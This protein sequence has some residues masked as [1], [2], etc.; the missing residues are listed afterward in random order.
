[1]A[2]GH[3][4]FGNFYAAGVLVHRGLGSE[5][6]DPAAQ[7]RV[8]QD[9]SPEVKERGGP[10]RYLRPPFEALLFSVFTIWP[11]PRALLIW[12]C[13]KLAMLAAIPFV[14]VRDRPWR[15]AFPLWATG[16]LALG[17]FP[18]S[19][20]LYLGQDAVLVALLYAI[21]FWQLDTGRDVAAGV[22][23]GLALV[24]F[25]FAIPFMVMLWI[26]G[27]KRVL[28]G[29]AAS[30][31]VLLV[32]SAAVVGWRELLLHYPIYLLTLNQ[33]TGVGIQ[34][35][36]QVTFRGLLTILVG[37][38]TYPGRIHFVLLPIAIGA[39]IY[40]GWL[41]RKA[42]SGF[43]AEG[44]GLAAIVAIVSSYY[45]YCY[46]MILLMVPMLAMLTRPANA[47]TADKVTGY[48]ETSGV[49]L[50]L[51]APVY[52]F[53]KSTLHHEGLMAIPL[54]AVGIALARR[55]RHA[56]A[57]TGVRAPMAEVAG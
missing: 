51:L 6:Y 21:V 22:T 52:W 45:A 56:G 31:S 43:L 10:I 27:R 41:W 3:F 34:P 15:E 14:V 36:L 33:R 26:A 39:V 46:D 47:P 55:L 2:K 53:A 49:L 28:P 24:K 44:F 38:A 32:I 50:L 8:Q 29:F 25:H 7:W 30:A 11:F 23:L 48:F 9:L 37:N 42:G 20:D 35:D 5:L 19:I 54:L 40:A 18:V 17:T 12:T 16:L 57:T 4:D 1:M 13:L